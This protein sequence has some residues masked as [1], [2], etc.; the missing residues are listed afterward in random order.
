MDEEE[1]RTLTAE[2]F[3]AA[4]VEGPNWAADPIPSLETWRRWRAAE[5]KA[6]AH[7]QAHKQRGEEQT[8]PPNEQ[9]T[10]THALHD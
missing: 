2:D 7:L 9:K 6:F 3:A 10:Q 1:R 5:E 8:P 4:G